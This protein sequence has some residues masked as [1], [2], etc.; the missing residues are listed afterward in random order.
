MIEQIRKNVALLTR[1][2][3]NSLFNTSDITSNKFNNILYYNLSNGTIT[4]PGSKMDNDDIR[5]LI[6]E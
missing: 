1:S 3:P 5:T 4:N 6:V 2:L